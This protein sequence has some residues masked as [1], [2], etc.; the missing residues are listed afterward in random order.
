MHPEKNMAWI[1]TCT[2][3]FIAVYN[4]QDMEATL[5][6]IDRGMGKKDVV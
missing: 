4:D 3:M 6:A 1:D 5:M 2:P